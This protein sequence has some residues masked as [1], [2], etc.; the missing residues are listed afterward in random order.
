MAADDEPLLDGEEEWQCR[1]CLASDDTD[2]LIAPCDC[3]GSARWVHRA[4]L[5]EWRAQERVPRAFTHC[6]T[7]K[8]EYQTR[9]VETPSNRQFYCL[10]VRD[11]ASLFL[12]VQGVLALLALFIHLCDSSGSIKM[13]YPP[14]WAET[15]AGSL[16]IGPYYVSAVILVL[17]VLGLVGVVLKLTGRMPE[18]PVIRRAP[19]SLCCPGHCRCEPMI[20]A[21]DC[22]FF[23]CDAC[24]R[25]CAEGACADCC[26]T[27][28]ICHG[29]CTHWVGT[30]ASSGSHARTYLQCTAPLI[31]SHRR[32]APPN[33]FWT[34]EKTS[35]CTYSPSGS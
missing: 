17:A 14:H 11:S 21:P 4:C 10:V 22:P 16:S 34:V 15:H 26:C 30:P 24:C 7:C 13:L 1:I 33:A 12:A 27:A 29:V 23:A 2:S 25:C 28:G 20:Y 31:S 5:D 9:V 19:R 3:R 35:D 6:P 32:R 8:F 18:R